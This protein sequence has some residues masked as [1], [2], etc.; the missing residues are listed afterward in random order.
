MTNNLLSTNLIHSLVWKWAIQGMS[1][2]AI[3]IIEV[4]IEDRHYI[5]ELI[6]WLDGCVLQNSNSHVTFLKNLGNTEL[7]N[8]E[9]LSS[10]KFMFT[11]SFYPKF[12][13][14]HS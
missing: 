1:N 7:Y 12:H 2:S 4:V 10:R 5:E 6:L 8:N 14:L 13:K 9:I 3:K 11:S